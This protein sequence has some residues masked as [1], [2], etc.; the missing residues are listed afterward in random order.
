MDFIRNGQAKEPESPF[1]KACLLG[2]SSFYPSSG[3]HLLVAQGAS[4][5]EG[6]RDDDSIWIDPHNPTIGLV[7]HDP[8]PATS[9]KKAHRGMLQDTCGMN[10]QTLSPSTIL[11]LLKLP[12]GVYVE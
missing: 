9:E 6:S 12:T 2:S 3:Q 11:V 7:A 10:I 1:E 8:A 5:G 4:L